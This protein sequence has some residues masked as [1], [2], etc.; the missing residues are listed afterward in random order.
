MAGEKSEAEYMAELEA[1]AS[2]QTVQ[3]IEI[4]GTDKLFDQPA[5]AIAELVIRLIKQGGVVGMDIQKGKQLK[6]SFV[7]EVR[8]QVSAVGRKGNTSLLSESARA[9]GEANQKKMPI[10]GSP[11][12]PV[13]S[14]KVSFSWSPVEGATQYQFVIA[15]DSALTSVVVNEGSWTPEH[16]P[17]HIYPAGMPLFWTVAALFD[18]GDPAHP[19]RGPFPTPKCFVFNPKLPASA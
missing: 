11:E 12:G 1:R 18:S 2:K 9:E 5:Q 8:D 10:L 3:T 7:E 14:P 19:I 17:G 16:T 4:P 13:A 15:Q 6:L